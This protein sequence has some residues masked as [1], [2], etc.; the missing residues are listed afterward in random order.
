MRGCLFVL[1]L[2][3]IVLAVFAWFGA[4]LVATTVI[5]AGLDN[6]GYRAATSTVSVTSDPPPRLLLGQADRVEI[7]GTDV[8]FRTFHASRLELTLTDVNVIARTA[9]HISGE[10]DGAELKTTDPVPTVADVTI[11]GAA[12]G[13]AAT[14]VVDG[15]TIDRLVKA[16]FQAKFGVTVTSTELVAPATL[17]VSAPGATVEG[18]FVVGPDNAI[19]LQTRLGSTEVFRLDPSFPLRFDAIAVEGGNL[20]IDGTLDAEKLIGG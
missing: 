20:R 11:D 17:R 15:A 14:I 10:I 3:A 6:A 1:V 19:S 9:G 4:P 2:A 16:A 12:S 5:Q 13:A 18:A 8:D 7:A